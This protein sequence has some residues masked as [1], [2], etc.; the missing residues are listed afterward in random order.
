MGITHLIL[1]MSDSFKELK[2]SVL[3]RYDSVLF[4]Q[5]LYNLNLIIIDY[6]NTWCF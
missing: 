2:T 6:K 1:G 5:R 3:R 4:L